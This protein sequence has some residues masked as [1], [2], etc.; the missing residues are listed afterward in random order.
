MMLIKKIYFENIQNIIIK[1]LNKSSVIG[2]L[3][4]IV[5]D[6]SC[7]I[8]SFSINDKYQNQGY[9]S[10]LLY[11]LIEYCKNNEIKNILLD[12]M[13]DR[14]NQ[15]NNIYIKFGFRYIEDGFPEMEL[16]I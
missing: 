8:N 14:F 15:Q 9:G 4:A 5:N 12:D 16:F 11:N 10:I 13:S 2:V 3:Y 6:N 7:H 1:I